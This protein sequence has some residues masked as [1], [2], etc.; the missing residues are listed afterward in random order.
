MAGKPLLALDLPTTT[1]S[2]E[3]ALVETLE[4]E[5][6]SAADRYLYRGQANE[7]RRRWPLTRGPFRSLSKA[8]LGNV[9]LWRFEPPSLTLPLPLEH[10]ILD[11]PSLIPTNTRAY[12]HYLARG[13]DSWKEDAFDDTMVHFWTAVCTFIL[14][15]ACRV[16]SDTAA[17]DWVLR[18]W[19][20]DYP[21]L[22]KLR[23]VGQHYGMDTGLLDATSSYQVALWFATHNFSTGEYRPNDTAVLYRIDRQH[24]PDVEAWLR[25]IPEH[26]GE[27]DAATVDIRDTPETIA[28]RAVRQKGWSLVGWDHPRMIIRMASEGFLT[29]YVFRTGSV[30][31]SANGLTRDYLVP[32]ADPT[33]IL[34]RIYWGEQP[35]SLDDAQAWIDRYWNIDVSSR[36][37]LD[38]DGAWFGQLVNEIAH[39][40]EVHEATI[41]KAVGHSSSD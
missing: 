27:F 1:F 24:L 19:N 39:V 2:S 14:G 8:D 10:G 15:L 17:L 13:P 5:Q 25:S 6:R 7:Y 11:L 37:V 3:E 12:E 30:P 29:R 38:E 41:R 26:E 16:W 31:S 28:A 33:G 21:A 20:E 32:L 18:Q 22:Y 35:R 34:F 9:G 40:Y 4:S 36:I 23:S